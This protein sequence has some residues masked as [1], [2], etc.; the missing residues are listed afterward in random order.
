MNLETNLLSY[1]EETKRLVNDPKRID[2]A[3]GALRRLHRLRQT[4]QDF[5]AVHGQ[6]AVA[7]ALQQGRTVE[8]LNGN[9]Y[10]SATVRRIAREIGMPK[11]RPGPKPVRS[12]NV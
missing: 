8:E 12:R 6:D 1:L 4:L 5:V 11:R 2:E 9:P 3:L 7:L 10:E